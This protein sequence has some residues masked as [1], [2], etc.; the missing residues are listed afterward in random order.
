MSNFNSLNVY[1]AVHKAY[2]HVGNMVKDIGHCEGQTPSHDGF[3]P[4]AWLPVTFWEKYYENWVTVMPGK[5]LALDPDGRFMPA[6]YG[7]TSQTLT[8]SAN[9]V[10][11]GTI[12]I[13]TGAAV[14]SAKSVTLSQVD[15]TT[16]GFMGRKGESFHDNVHKY[17]VGVC[18]SPMLQWAGDGA[19]G[20]DGF[21][22]AHYINHNYNMQHKVCPLLDYVIKLPFIPGKVSAESVPNSWTGSALP[23]TGSGGWRTVTYVAAN[24]AGRY[25]ATTGLYPVLSTYPLCGLSL[26]N[27][28]V[29]KNTT[30]T[31]ITCTVSG[32]LV[33]EVSGPDAISGTGDYWVDYEVGVLMVYSAGGTSLPSVS[34]SDTITYWH[35]ATAAGTVSCFGCVEATTDEL[36]PGDY[37]K[38]ST[39]S[40]FVRADPGSD[41]F[42]LIVGQVLGL[43]SSYPKD[44]LDRVR[45]AYSPALTTSA[46]G[47]MSAGTAGSASY[48]RGAYDQLTGSATSGIDTQ[49]TYAGGANTI[50]LVNLIGK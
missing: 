46:I 39:N 32:L 24:A 49:I 1:S 14:S 41:A 20:D 2:D 31:P 47:S 35:N 21:N 3:M 37:L 26:D 9:D 6:Q 25:N 16:Y 7:L 13:T 36:M 22:P 50:V 28:S 40:N 29:A 44:Y 48:N 18:W 30:R 10:A 5:V 45:T 33:N 43:D 4:A 11:A 15:G 12:D 42:Y 19:A 17:P 34:G 27:Q 8:Y 38:V 23:L